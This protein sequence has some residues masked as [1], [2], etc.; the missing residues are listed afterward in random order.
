LEGKE[1]RISFILTNDRNPYVTARGGDDFRELGPEEGTPQSGLFLLDVRPRLQ[2]AFRNAI[3]CNH[4]HYYRGSS[5][6]EDHRR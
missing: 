4:S 5:P 2:I 6:H 3:S 1:R